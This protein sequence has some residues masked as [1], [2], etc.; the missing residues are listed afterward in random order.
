MEEE[1][2]E[3]INNDKKD[4]TVI[5][6]NVPN[7]KIKIQTK[8]VKKKIMKRFSEISDKVKFAFVIILL[9]MIFS[10]MMHLTKYIIKPLFAIMFIGLIISLNIF[11]KIKYKLYPINIKHKS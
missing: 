8:R 4:H 7:K 6:V 1:S 3:L 11:E 10:F 2:K 9:V 5:N